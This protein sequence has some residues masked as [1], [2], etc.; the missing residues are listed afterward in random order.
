MAPQ[1]AQYFDLAEAG[2]AQVSAWWNP[3]LQWYDEWLDDRS[4]TPLASLWGT[5][6]LFETLDQLAIAQPTSANIAAVN[7]F[8]GQEQRYWDA[9]VTPVPG[10]APYPV[11]AG[12]TQTT[13]FDDNGWFGLAFL[14]AYAATG[15]LQDLYHAE[16]AFTFAASGWDPLTGGVFFHTGATAKSG[17]SLGATTELAAR[18]YQLTKAPAYLTWAQTAIAWAHTNLMNPNGTYAN[19]F[20][21][22]G[23][24]TEPTMPHNAQGAMIDALE[25]LCQSTRLKS[26]CTQAENLAS[27]ALRV[28]PP[29]DQG[30]QYD[31]IFLR[32]LLVLYGYDHNPR[33]YRFV[34]A[35]AQRVLDNT[36]N[37]AGRYLFNWNGS[38]S[39]A[40][41][42]PGLL[43]TEAANIDVF[44]ALATVAP[45]K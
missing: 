21:D 40:Y 7:K 37:A 16:N 5:V 12:P 23:V 35:N 29:L 19:N 28:F 10:Y 1:T 4:V 27:A 26:W 32:D 15:T 34:A 3:K 22:D 36:R 31:T 42:S 30:P 33:W 18:L 38:N 9:S 45:P 41:G 44:A 13:Y 43:R 2:L 39:I 24:I 11:E 20:Y 6:P 17:E 8:A 25:S 14:D